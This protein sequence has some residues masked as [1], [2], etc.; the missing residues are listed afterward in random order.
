MSDEQAE[1]TVDQLVA[2]YRKIRSAK[3][4]IEERQKAELA[5]LD[6]QLD[7]VSQQ[8]LDICQKQNV[9]S[10]STPSGTVSRRVWTRY[11]TSDWDS[12]YQFMQE[13]DAPFLLE[14]RIH[15]GNMQQFLEENP[16]L[17]PPGLQA[18]SMYVMIVRKPTGT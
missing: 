14:Q 8:L 3:Q 4:E 1:Y 2:I 7:M 5:E 17:H 13:H 9:D 11:W 18:D 6:E 15:K 10:L 16:D 12:M